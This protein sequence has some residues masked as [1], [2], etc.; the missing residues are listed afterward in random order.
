MIKRIWLYPPLAFARVGSSPVPCKNFDWGPDDLTPHGTSRTRVRGIETLQVTKDGTILSCPPADSVVFRDQD[1]VRPVCPFFELHGAWDD[2]GRDDEGP[3]TPGLLARFNMSA[4][5]LTWTICVVNDKAYHLTH[6]RGDRIAA[7]LQIL[8]DD[9]GKQPLEGRSS[10]QKS[11]P[12]VPPDKFIPFGSVQLTK[13]SSDLPEFRLRFTPGAGKVYAP[14]NLMERIADLRFPKAPIQDVT[15]AIKNSTFTQD[16]V[17]ALT[18]VCLTLNEPWRGFTLPEPQRLL[19]PNSSWANHCTLSVSDVMATLPRLLQRLLDLYTLRS[20]ADYSE[21]VRMLLT[22]GVDVGNLPP[23]LFAFA[24]EPPKLISSLGMIDDLGDGLITAELKGMQAAAR[25]VIAPPSYAPDRRQPVSLADGL[26]DRVGR[27]E[28]REPTWVDGDNAQ[29]ADAEVHDLLDRAYE[30]VGLQNVD[31]VVDLFRLENENR[32][33]RGDSPYSP[34][35]ARELLWEGAK[36]VSIQPMPLLALARQHHR[37]NTVR[38][39]FENFVRETDHWLERFVREPAGEQ[40]FYDTRMP[41]VMRGFDRRP[42]HL[43]RRQY[44]LLT[45]WTKRMRGQE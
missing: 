36:L 10:D 2:N 21:L 40:R 1:G 23:G 3:I 29:A 16:P 17:A 42:L 19:N 13:P 9:C 32:A 45:A 18:E 26:A 41:G 28:V 25:V 44:E 11:D 37:H 4:S 34:E 27:S 14:A 43:T 8:G 5:D 30:T 38:E 7:T 20:R 35:K 6:S 22:P 12:L 24:V 31:A 33:S 39:R 15:Q